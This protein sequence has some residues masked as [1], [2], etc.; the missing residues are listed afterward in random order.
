MDEEVNLADLYGDT[1]TSPRPLAVA[2]SASIANVG[3]GAKYNDGGTTAVGSRSGSMAGDNMRKRGGGGG[4][5]R[6]KGW[7]VAKFFGF[8]KQVRIHKFTYSRTKNTYAKIHM[9][10]QTLRMCICVLLCLSFC[11]TLWME[12]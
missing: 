6:S 11:L 3:S 4:G 1:S 9:R 7:G 2:T 10:S 12:I 5:G 8:S